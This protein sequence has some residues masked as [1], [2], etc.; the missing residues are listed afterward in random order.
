MKKHR[1]LAVLMGLT[2]VLGACSSTPS[3]TTA[4]EATQAASEPAASAPT[5]AVKDACTPADEGTVVPVADKPAEPVKIAVLGLENNP[6]WIP[7]KG[8]A[9]KAGEELAALGSSVEWI[10]PGDQHTS[11]VFGQAIEAAIVKGY[12]GIATVA[13][14]AG[15]VPFINKA[16][17]AG[18]PVATFNSETAEPND[19][20]FFVGADLY[21]QG[22][23]AGKA[24]G[25]ATRRQG[26][27]RDHHRPVRRRGARA[28]AQGLRGHPSRRTSRMS[29]SS[30]PSR[31]RTRPT[32]PTRRR[33]TS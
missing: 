16:V 13:G 26:Q 25:E 31:T 33:T 1:L 5:G 32:S 12:D 11:E 23:A 18:I 6:F 7:V 2:V 9:E 30:R 10:V 20:M 19:R 8:G 27:G 3:S 17:A 22:E 24:M 4:P 21:K 15:L 28:P 14:D 29:R